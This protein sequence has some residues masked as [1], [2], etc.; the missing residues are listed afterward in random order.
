MP[1][2]TPEPPAVPQACNGIAAAASQGL[3]SWLWLAKT[4]PLETPKAGPY[5]APGRTARALSIH[6]RLMLAI[7]L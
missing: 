6:G 5:L 3:A 4:T 2:I 7:P 1:S